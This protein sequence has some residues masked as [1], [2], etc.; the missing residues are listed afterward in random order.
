MKLSIT[1]LEPRKGLLQDIL[2]HAHTQEAR[3]HA[4]RHFWFFS[5]FL[6]LSTCAA[7]PVLSA[8]MQQAHESGFVDVLSLS[9]SDTASIFIH[10]QEYG[11]SLLETLPINTLIVSVGVLLS[12]LIASHSLVRTSHRSY[13]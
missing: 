8:L 13:T 11:Y 1:L 2:T 9:L 10:W 3:L 5:L 4:R 6:I 12:C 7:V